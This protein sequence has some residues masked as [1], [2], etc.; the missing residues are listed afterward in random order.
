MF[1]NSDFKMRP[2]ALDMKSTS[3]I[4]TDFV[5]LTVNDQ[6]VDIYSPSSFDCICGRGKQSFNHIG[7][8][9]FRLIVS[10]HIERYIIALSRLDKSLVVA[11]IVDLIRASNGRFI[12]MDSKAKTWVELSDHVTR[13]KVGHALRD[14]ICA[15]EKE[16]KLTNNR[17]CM[18]TLRI[19]AISD[20]SELDRLIVVQ[21]QFRVQG[22]PTPGSQYNSIHSDS[23]DVQRVEPNACICHEGM[24]LKPSYRVPLP[25]STMKEDTSGKNSFKIN[26][27]STRIFPICPTSKPFEMI[28][29]HGHQVS[30][31]HGNDNEG[32][33][34]LSCVVETLVDDD[35]SE[36]TQ[37]EPFVVE[38]GDID[39]DPCFGSFVIEL[40]GGQLEDPSL[41]QTMEHLHSIESDNT[42]YF[43]NIARRVSFDH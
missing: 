42:E 5:S 4:V 25:V 28:N 32:D 29:Y 14:A 9:R 35:L 3:D 1:G 17:F 11:S 27:L 12:K 8:V 21:N 16:A 31:E 36:E 18:N 15:R 40:F 34:F 23:T 38:S 30:Q 19:Q 37:I 39:I 24:E 7:N 13:E 43:S 33:D 41:D 22:T 26:S 6:L 2:R 10:L 20:L